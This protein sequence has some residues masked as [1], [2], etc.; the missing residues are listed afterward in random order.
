MPTSLDSALQERLTE[1]HPVTG[2]YLVAVSGGRDSMVLLDWLVR[3]GFKN[4]TVLHFN[5]Q[6]RGPESDKDVELV[7]GRCK[8][9]KLAFETGEGNV[10]AFASANKLSIETAARRMRYDWMA[11]V[12]ARLKCNRLFLAHHAD[13]QVETVLI[14]LFRGSGARG[15]SGMDEVSK[16]TIGGTEMELIRPFLTV[17]RAEID[18]YVAE[19]GVLFREDQSN[20]E[21]F[22]LRNRLR[23]DL[24]PRISECFERDVSGAVLRAAELARLDEALITELIPDPL[25]LNHGLDVAALRKTPEALRNRQ[26]L[27]WLRQSGVPNCG[28][29]EV[30]LVAEVAL[31][32]AKPAK[33]NLPGTFH[34]RRKEGVLFIEPPAKA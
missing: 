19:H 3:T 5:H 34:A 33:A 26:L 21:G 30:L 11:E 8:E 7:R 31:S 20:A 6:L 2:A 14:N 12:A 15:I 22:A 18:R 16:R 24:L 27:R 28:Q 25:K 13:D 32:Q 29:R 9:L 17:T 4:L 23:N 10:T 1:R